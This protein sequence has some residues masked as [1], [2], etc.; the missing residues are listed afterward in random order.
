[1]GIGR[2]NSTATPRQLE[3]SAVSGT[4]VLLLLILLSAFAVIHSSHA[5]RQLY[6]QLQVLEASRWHLQ[7]DHGRLLLEQS[8][9]ASHYRVEK[10]A[11]GELG[12]SPPAL[13]SR[14]VIAP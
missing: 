8:T 5:C 6:T 12:M 13:E 1:M 9:W 11:E 3:W 4:A 2:V 14:A 7:E 10:V